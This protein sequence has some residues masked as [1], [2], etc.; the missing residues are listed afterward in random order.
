MGDAMKDMEYLDYVLIIQPGSGGVYNV[1][2]S[3]D[4]GEPDGVLEIPPNLLERVAAFE[5]NMLTGVVRGARR[6]FTLEATPNPDSGAVQL[7]TDLFNILVNPARRWGFVNSLNMAKQQGKGLRMVLR[8]KAPELVAIPWELATDP[9]TLMPL[10]ASVET[11]IVR[12]TDL[13]QARQKN[14]TV[15]PPVRILGVI[16]SPKD[17]DPLDVNREKTRLEAALSDTSRVQLEWLEQPTREALMERL[18]SSTWHVLHFIGH[19]DFDPTTNDSGIALCDDQG[20]HDLFGADNL[21]WALNDSD[22]LRLV[23]LNSCEGG[24]SGTGPFS[25]MAAKL[26]QLGIP[27]VL[28]MQYPITD[29]AA[30]AFS[31]SLYR[32]LAAGEPVDAAVSKAR[33]AI[34]NDR[35]SGQGAEWATPVL[36][37]RSS[38]GRL[39]APQEPEDK[40]TSIPV[41]TNAS[42]PPIQPVVSTP[43][44]AGSSAV[45]VHTLRSGQVSPSTLWGLPLWGWLVLS[46]AAAL[47][48]FVLLNQKPSAVPP[49]QSATTPEPNE[50]SAVSTANTTAI[51]PLPSQAPST[52]TASTEIQMPSGTWIGNAEGQQGQFRVKLTLPT[53]CEIGGNCGQL[54][55]SNP[56][57]VGRIKLLSSANA[58]LEFDVLS[59]SEDSSSECQTGA[60][61]NIE[62]VDGS[63]LLYTTDYDPA[64]NATL[65]QP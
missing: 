29:E 12:Y 52:S 14:I 58:I 61:E 8:I 18:T 24:R 43:V 48:I 30:K 42:V 41:P 13:S 35:S 32:T 45:Q 27:A 36:Y 40:P 65:K 1:T 59:F 2:G 37:M 49:T 23:V 10:A 34:K 11:P 39:F 64:I 3:A 19:G 44:Q 54:V 38:D 7:G 6:D 21:R 4:G 60:G 63:T 33:V 55:I 16:S 15:A 28:A 17:L 50:T 9:D 22:T 26:M 20:N 31:A 47:L 46:A 5:K 56:Y 57:C 51:T 25:S 62:M 53:S